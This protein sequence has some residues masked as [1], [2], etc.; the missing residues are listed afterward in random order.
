MRVAIRADG[1][2]TIG[3]GHLRRCRQI[4]RALRDAGCESLLL[5]RATALPDVAGPWSVLP[6]PAHLEPAAEPAWVARAAGEHNCA[7]VLVDHYGWSLPMLTAL[8]NGCSYVALLDDG[9]LLASPANLVVNGAVA[10]A[11]L[12]YEPAPHQRLLLGPQYLPLAEEYAGI[13]PR[14]GTG[15][16]R[17]VVISLGGA[18][19][20]AI[21]PLALRAVMSAAPREAAVQVVTGPYF[22]P[23]CS[24]Q[25]VV[26][27]AAWPGRVQ[28]ILA[29][30]S[31]RDLLVYAD[32]AVIAGGGTVYEAAAAGC[33]AVGVGVAQ[34]QR[35]NL[36][37]MARAGTLR[38]AGWAGDGDLG[39]RIGALV[40]EL[41][42]RPADRAAMA[43]AGQT[44]VDGRG[45][46]RLVSE[47]I[48]DL[49]E[50]LGVAH[51]PGR[52]PA[53]GPGTSRFHHRRGRR[54]P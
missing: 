14:P 18:D 1:G 29:P 12:P 2:L 30:D 26:T 42:E 6:V 10:A 37:G 3:L 51:A 7:A 16:V 28:V 39:T 25:V 40:A 20:L 44:L 11:D 53:G 13:P 49:K 34:N 21:T 31:L 15:P 5:T 52:Q 35:P 47:A 46:R 54:Q 24:E 23:A 48:R 38:D 4:A 32:L 17:R 45:A 50:G 19:P 9:Q 33:P 8:R 22:S 36:A 41:A 27:A 43:R